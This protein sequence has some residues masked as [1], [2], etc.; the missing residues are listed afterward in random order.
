MKRV[1]VNHL[2]LIAA[3]SVV[4]CGCSGSQHVIGYDIIKSPLPP[5]NLGALSILTL[6]DRRPK[7]EQVG[8]KGKMLSFSSSNGH[9][10]KKVPM[11]I[12]EILCTEL[13][14]A[15]FSVVQNQDGADY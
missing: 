12:T 15:G 10:S 5:T 6:E 2:L 7:P 3:L 9:F 11:A 13:N 8:V 4:L 14:N 1:Q